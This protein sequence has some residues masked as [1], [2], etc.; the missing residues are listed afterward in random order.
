MKIVNRGF[1]FIKPSP[2][3]IEWVKQIDP[4]L[5]IDEQ[6]EGSVYLIEEEFWDDELILKNYAKKIAAQEMSG[7]TEEAEQLIHKIVDIYYKHRI[8]HNMRPGEIILIDN[9]RAVHGRSPFFPK[10][11]G[12]DRFLI[13]CFST[14]DYEKSSYARTDS[15]RVISAIYS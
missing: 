6:A 9:N 14:F 11:D 13:R 7:I 2:A 4:E 1:I 3:F 8:E 10:F 5:L 15:C 12:N